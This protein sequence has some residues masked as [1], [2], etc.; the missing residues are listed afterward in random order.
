[1]A[2]LNSSGDYVAKYTYD[3]WGNILSVTDN[4]G[5][6]ITS[7]THIGNM[8]P[9]RYRG[10]YYDSETK[11]Y[12]LQSR[13]YDPETGRF[14]NADGLVQ[15]GQGVLD[16]NMFAYSKNNPVMLIDPTG[17]APWAI[18]TKPRIPNPKKLFG[19]VKKSYTPF[20]AA[21]KWSNTYISA[22]IIKGREMGA[23]IYADTSK[24]RTTYVTGRTFTGG[25]HDIILGFTNGYTVAQITTI[26]SER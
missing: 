8:N 22:S 14:L 7:A 25:K 4:S 10:Y 1:M 21:K 20:A 6:A 13:Y 2:I 24:R 26:K 5:A 17:A 11:F 15:T 18:P 9:I 12:Y 16:K 19:F 23:F 3:A